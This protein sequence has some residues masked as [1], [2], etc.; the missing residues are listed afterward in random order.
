MRE[1]LKL[2]LPGIFHAFHVE[3]FWSRYSDGAVVNQWS[4]DLI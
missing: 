3:I 2:I 1:W 4:G